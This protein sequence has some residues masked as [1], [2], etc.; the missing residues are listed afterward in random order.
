MYIRTYA[1]A[2][3]YVCSYSS[4]S[5]S[6]ESLSKVY[7]SKRRWM[8]R[9]RFWI[10]CNDKRVTPTASA[11]PAHLDEGDSNSR[12]GARGR[13]GPWYC[14]IEWITPTG[15]TRTIST[16]RRDNYKFV[17]NNRRVTVNP[18]VGALVG[19]HLAV[20]LFDIRSCSVIELF[21]K[22]QSFRARIIVDTFAVRRQW[23]IFW[24]RGL[25]LIIQ[26]KISKHDLFSFLQNKFLSLNKL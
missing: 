12:M 22:W 19:F 25:S 24:R 2:G 9:N 21:Y 1:T 10:L 15:E 14:I 17:I 8:D 11:S 23:S 20:V 16:V 18:L 26:D 7:T 5:P 3:I 13:S 6:H 4:R